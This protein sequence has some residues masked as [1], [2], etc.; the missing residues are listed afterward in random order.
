MPPVPVHSE[1]ISPALWVALSFGP[2][3]AG[4]TGWIA[5]RREAARLAGRSVGARRPGLAGPLP[6][7]A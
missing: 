3:L 2:V 4:L 7:A 6:R 5:A 1:F